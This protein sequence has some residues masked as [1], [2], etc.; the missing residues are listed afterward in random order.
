[1]K[2]KGHFHLALC[3]II[4]L[5]APWPGCMS[6][7]FSFFGGGLCHGNVS[8]CHSRKS[9]ISL[10]CCFCLSCWMGSLAGFL[11][12]RSRGVAYFVSLFV[13][14][15]FGSTMARRSTSLLTWMFSYTSVYLRS[16][17]SLIVASS[18]SSPRVMT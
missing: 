11:G 8:F 1:M 16:S 15:S 12:S 14:M 3:Q 4:V 6:L 9:F 10:P 18:T 13:S 5:Y 2:F 17:K 7:F